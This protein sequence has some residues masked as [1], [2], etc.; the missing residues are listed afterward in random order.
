MYIP[1]KYREADREEIFE[2]VRAH[3]FGLLISAPGTDSG[4]TP[5]ATHLPLDILKRPDGSWVLEGHLARA[6][7]QSKAIA[8]GTS[9]LCVFSGP[10][11]YVSSSWYQ[12]EEVPTWNYMAV[13]LSGRYY[14]QSEDE[15]RESLRRLVDHYEK[16][17]DQPVSLDGFSKPV[18]RQIRGILGFT[19][20]ID[21]VDAAYKL[22][23]G[24]EADH[25]RIH[26]ELDKRNGL[27]AEVSK[28]MRRNNSR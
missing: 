25:D 1:D 21:T 19:I 8:D 5:L 6:N 3:A 7:P 9:V 10:H 4:Q 28:Q 15:L 12:E 14:R 27:S 16:D 18:M 2:F 13:H 17:S 11:A 24:R 22:S 26:K 23:Q 20:E